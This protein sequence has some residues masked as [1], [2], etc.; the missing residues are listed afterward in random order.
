MCFTEIEVNPF[1]QGCFFVI[2][3]STLSLDLGIGVT[4]HTCTQSWRRKGIEVWP[5]RGLNGLASSLGGRTKTCLTQSSEAGGWAWGGGGRH[6][7]K[8]G[9]ATQPW[10]HVG[11]CGCG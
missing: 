2:G 7:V 1:S 6:Q 5:L 11:T 9:W 10:G 8:V 4:L 3:D